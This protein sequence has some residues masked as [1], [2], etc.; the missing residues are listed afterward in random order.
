MKIKTECKSCQGTGLYRGMAEP[1][2]VAVVC[3]QCKGTGCVEIEIDYIP[4]TE[5]KRRNDVEKVYLS[6]GSFILSCGPTGESV[7]YDEFMNGKM[8]TE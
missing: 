5:R 3:L 2:G 1:E 8:P 7:T 4:F 6:R